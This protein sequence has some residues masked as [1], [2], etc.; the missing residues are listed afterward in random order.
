MDVVNL[1]KMILSIIVLIIA[2]ICSYIELKKNPTYIL[3][4]LFAGF[5]ILL[6]FGVF[7][8]VLYHVVFNNVNL[9]LFLSIFSNAS[10]NFGFGFIAL[11]PLIIKYSE[12]LDLRKYVIA[13]FGVAVLTLCGY[14]IWPISVDMEKYERGI[15]STITE[16]ALMLILSLYKLI[17]VIYILVEYIRIAKISEDETKERMKKFTIGMIFLILGLF[18]TFFASL[19]KEL[20]DVIKILSLVMFGL[21]IISITKALAPEF[22][23]FGRLTKG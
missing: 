12:K 8:Y 20:A 5:I 11:T 23:S 17:I 22:L 19:F 7:T 2:I 16:P 9:V 21:T 13:V 4:K 10:F 1:I 15:V 3:N 18:M 14:F 6:A